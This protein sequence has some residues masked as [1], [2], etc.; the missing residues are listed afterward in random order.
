MTRQLFKAIID[1]ETIGHS[2]AEGGGQ[3]EAI[4][5]AVKNAIKGNKLVKN[6]LMNKK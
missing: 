5:P 2:N 3:N 1:N 4:D 6:K